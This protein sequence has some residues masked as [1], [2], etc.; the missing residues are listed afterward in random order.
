MMPAPLPRHRAQLRL[1]RCL[2]PRPRRFTVP[3]LLQR[4]KTSCSALQY[5]V[6]V[7]ATISKWVAVGRVTPDIALEAPG[8]SASGLER[9]GDVGI[10]CRFYLHQPD[11]P[12]DSAFNAASAPP[13]KSARRRSRGSWLHFGAAGPSFNAFVLVI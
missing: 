4:R 2:R 3:L 7:K 9:P 12:N 1:M 6:G 13:C 8:C 11:S 5:Q 10:K